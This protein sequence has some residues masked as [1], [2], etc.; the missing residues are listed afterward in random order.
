MEKFI[1]FLGFDSL[2]FKNN[3]SVC[4]ILITSLSNVNKFIDLF[5]ECKI[6]RAKALD[7]ANFCKDIN[8][9]NKKTHL[10]KEGI[11]IIKKLSNNMNSTQTKFK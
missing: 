7:Y 2:T 6:L 4:K 1:K 9:I 5:K 10:N 11:T 3:K 8:L